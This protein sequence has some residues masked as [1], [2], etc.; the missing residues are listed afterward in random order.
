MND[1]ELIAAYLEYEERRG[2]V[3]T[4]VRGKYLSIGKWEM[5]LSRRGKTILTAGR[6][7]AAGYLDS[8][9]LPK[10]SN[11]A[12]VV[13]RGFY[14]FLLKRDVLLHNPCTGVPLK[15]EGPEH[16]LGIFTEEEIMKMLSMIDTGTPVGLR[17]RAII[18]LL[19]SSGIRRGELFGLDVDDVNMRTRELTIRESKNGSGRV[20]PFGKHARVALSAWFEVRERFCLPSEV[21]ARYEGGEALFLD[22]L[23]QRLHGNVVWTMIRRYKKLAHV[24]SR[25]STHAFRHSCATHL[26]QH[27]APIEMVQRML[28]HLH[29][30]STTEYLH[31]DVSDL[32][33]LHER[34]HP[35]G[36]EEIWKI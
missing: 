15:R 4:S 7:D 11:R 19:Y 6:E 23:G 22:D 34:S 33:E 3:K 16:H 8:I 18:E 9:Y 26:L 32:C 30:T 27:G 20:V 14:D 21:E 24:T 12:H 17:D 35:R 1:T 25:G 28:G 2:I 31:E 13:L 5:F 29:V 36:K 10:V